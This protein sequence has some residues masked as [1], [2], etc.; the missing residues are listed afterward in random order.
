MKR[1]ARE[2]IE[3]CLSAFDTHILAAFQCIDVNRDYRLQQAELVEALVPGTKK[4]NEFMV[5]LGLAFE[6][7]DRPDETEDVETTGSASRGTS[8]REPEIRSISSNASAATSAPYI[9]EYYEV[10]KS[11][12]EKL[13]VNLFSN[14]RRLVFVEFVREQNRKIEDEK[15]L[16]FGKLKLLIRQSFDHHDVNNNG[17]LDKKESSR[18]FSHYV[19]QTSDFAQTVSDMALTY[20]ATLCMKLLD[21]LRVESEVQIQELENLIRELRDQQDLAASKKDQEYFRKERHGLEKEIPELQ[22]QYEMD[23]ERLKIDFEKILTDLQ[24]YVTQMKGEA[25]QMEREYVRNKSE[26]DIAGFNVIDINRDGQLQHK[27]FIAALTPETPRNIEFLKALGFDFERGQ[28]SNFAVRLMEQLQG[29]AP[30]KAPAKGLARATHDAFQA[31][32][33]IEAPGGGEMRGTSSTSTCVT[34][35]T[36]ESSDSRRR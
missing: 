10:L 35:T 17:V 11:Y 19:S 26:R 15:E 21:D 28:T 14:P 22:K 7:D 13:I 24:R 32:L 18:L 20:S 3:E 12:H 2:R 8:S 1:K 4:H 25:K 30:K 33:D 23:K 9:K 16:I 29:R 27:E 31:V 5:A 6:K 34:L 36:H